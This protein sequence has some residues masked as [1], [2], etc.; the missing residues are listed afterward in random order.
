MVNLSIT[1][2]AKGIMYFAYNSERQFSDTTFY[3]R[4]LINVDMS[5]RTLNVYGQN[6]WAGVQH[7]DSILKKWSPNIMSFD[8]TNRASYILRNEINNL[9][10]ETYFNDVLS[11]KPNPAIIT[12]PLTTPESVSQRYLQVAKFNN[13]DEQYSKYFMIVNRRCSPI[14]TLNPG[15]ENGRRSVTVKLDSSS[16][17]FAGFNNLSIY[18]LEK[19][20]L[21]KTFDKRTYSTISLGWFNPG[22]GKLYKIAPVMQEGGTLIADESFGGVTFVCK[23]TVTSNGKNITITGTTTTI[24]FTDSA[25]IIM[26]DANFYCGQFNTGQFITFKGI[27]NH[28]WRGLSLNNSNVKIY[29]SKFQDIASPVVNFAVK[30]LN[31][32][33]GDIRNNQFILNSDTA[34]GIRSSYLSEEEVQSFNLYINYNT[35][36]MNN[37]RTNAVQV[38]GFSD[39]TLPVYFQHN[40]MTSNGYATGIMLSTI[41]GGV[42]SHNNLTGFS[43]G[44]NVMFTF[45]DFYGNGISNTSSSSTGIF[46]S[47]GSV[48]NLSNS[49]DGVTAGANIITNTSSNSKNIYVQGARFLLNY[50]LNRFHVASSSPTQNY[51]LYGTFPSRTYTDYAEQNCFMINSTEITSPSLPLSA[52]YTGGLNGSLINFDFFPYNCSIT[53]PSGY[54]IVDIGN[55][56]YDTIPVF[57][58]GFG[59]GMKDNDKLPA[60]PSGRQITNYESRTFE[61]NEQKGRDIE[62]AVSSKDLY[63]SISIQMRYR[64]YSSVKILCYELINNYPDSLESISSLSILYLSELKTDTSANGFTNLKSFYENLILEN[65]ENES[66]VSSCNYLIQKCKVRLGQYQSAMDGFEQIINNNPYSYEGLLA[67]WDYAA[68]SLLDTTGGSGGGEADLEF[69]MSDLGITNITNIEKFQIRNS[70]SQILN[71]DPKNKNDKYDRKTFT[72]EDRKIIKQ[73][74]F[75]SFETAREKEIRN[76]KELE[77]K[78]EEGNANETEKSELQMKKVLSDIVK[79]KEPK[80]IFEHL[81]IVNND[82]QKVFGSTIDNSKEEIISLIPTEYSLSQN[83]PN[84]FNPNTKISFDLPNDSKI[85]LIVYDLLGREVIRLINSEFKIAGR[86]TI[87]FF[88]SNLSSGIYFYKI[89]A[90]DFIATKK[91]VLLK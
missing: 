44:M 40:T 22:D 17:Q 73:N 70:K 90:G 1:Y 18:D 56:L 19:D 9:K 21:I 58:G 64:N 42:I 27:H 45:A 91:M 7:I 60:S 87:D 52:I 37:S 38:Q 39:I 53:E 81:S 50:G 75:Q 48:I 12:N 35:F 20:S 43:K 76:I 8:N 2:G 34:G 47:S 11:Y 49:I 55:G 4:G 82:I 54:D 10:D 26:D 62:I 23:D 28:K 16:S 68:T 15:G 61:A 67:S 25:T 46:A 65:S 36:T 31:C 5:P 41:T 86:Y 88:G 24:D 51:H 59:G 84:P 78:V 14:V 69:G 3:E 85:K 33:L 30:M 72:K 79:L 29:N 89:E 80:D 71:D 74:V 57:E 32:P 83:Y 13:P 6:K 77:T 66:M 63:D